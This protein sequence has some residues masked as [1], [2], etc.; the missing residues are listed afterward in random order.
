MIVEADEGP[1]LIPVEVAEDPAQHQLGLM[2]REVLD[3][4]AGMLFM[5]FEDTSGGFWMKD[6]KIPLSIAFF[7][8]RGKI[9]RILDMEPCRADPC[10]VYE[11]GVV[12]R[13]ALEVNVGA[14]EEWGIA[15]GDILRV[16]R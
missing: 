12:Y 11:P 13:G 5:F 15:E 2:H 10:P 8:R 3:P 16:T 6:T 1:V 7:D 14:F 9:L 4:D